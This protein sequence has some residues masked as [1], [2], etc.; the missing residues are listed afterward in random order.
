MKADE[1]KQ[2]A[3]QELTK[4]QRH[5]FFILIAAV[6]IISMILVSISLS[7]YNSS[8][9]AQVDLSLP[10]YQSIRKQAAQDRSEDSFS[11]NGTLDA[12]AFNSF[13]S[14]YA[15]HLKRIGTE[16]YDSL[17]LSDDS[18]QLFANPATQSDAATDTTN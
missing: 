13:D 3:I 2:E 17:P 10:S 5:R 12:D 14:L 9:A 16:N 15:G 7:L 11:S 8:G 18:L 4:W 6:L 1:L